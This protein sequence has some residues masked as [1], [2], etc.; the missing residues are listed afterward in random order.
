MK[1]K[2]LAMVA[3]VGLLCLSACSNKESFRLTGEIEGLADSTEVTLIPTTM[4]KFDDAVGTV[5]VEKGKFVFEGV[6]PE[7]RAYVISVGGSLYNEPFLLKN[8]N[9]KLK[10]KAVV[11]NGR[12][13]IESIK[14][15]GSKPDREFRKH[16]A[17]REKLDKAFMEM[18][19]KHQEI[20]EKI[21]NARRA[22]DT[23]T[24]E[25]LYATEEWAEEERDEKE[26]FER[27]ERETREAIKSSA[28]SIYA[29]II[30]LYT[31]NY[32]PP[33]DP[34][35]V[36]LFESFPE[37]VQNGYFGEAVKRELMPEN[38]KGKEL[39][40]F[41]APDKSG[42][43]HTDAELRK[44]KRYVLVDFWASWCGPCRRE[45]PNLKA[46]YEEYAPKGLEIISVSVDRDE[47]A[48]LK[49]LEEEQ[50][51]WPNL[52]DKDNFASEKFLVK[53][54]PAIFLVDSDGIVMD[55]KLRGEALATRLAEL[56]N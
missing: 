43:I 34:D 29:P 55:D 6:A 4:H 15:S 52:I 1:V 26:F 35:L 18:R 8:G 7:P 10:G 50:L 49:A 36:E 32:I 28:K 42:T 56:F 17:F 44:D 30:I 22:N 21:M 9:I 51:P 27:V 5:L 41:S 23:E 16:I 13:K 25:E 53:T 46:L 20:D 40:E 37:E 2:S 48:W 19:E 38:L 39:P 45:I 11:E 24:L 14:L 54:I 12:P 47:A 33:E 31:Y 3:A